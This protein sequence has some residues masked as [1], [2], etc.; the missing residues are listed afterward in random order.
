VSNISKFGLANCSASVYE[1][2]GVACAG[3]GVVGGGYSRTGCL[4]RIARNAIMEVSVQ[5]AC[6]TKQ[7]N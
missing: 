2:L 4:L 6:R 3:R 5:G 7:E 1:H